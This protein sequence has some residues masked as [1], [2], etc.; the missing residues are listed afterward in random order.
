MTNLKSSARLVLAGALFT[1]LT[2]CSGGGYPAVLSNPGQSPQTGSSGSGGGATVNSGTGTTACKSGL[3]MSADSTFE[4]CVSLPANNATYAAPPPISV[5]ATSQTGISG[6]QAYVD[7]NLVSSSVSSKPTTTGSTGWWN[8]TISG[9]TPG[10][11]TIGI[12]VWDNNAPSY[13][14]NTYSA[15]ITVAASPLP[16]PPAGA[17]TYTNLESAAGSQGTWQICNGSCSG[18]SGPGS[19]TITQNATNAPSLSGSALEET[20]TGAAFNTLGYLKPPCPTAGCTSVSNFVDD[21]WF[22]I[23]A[24]TNQLQALEFDPDVYDGSYEY[25]MSMQC[26]SVSGEWRFWNMAAAQWTVN[27]SSGQ[28]I[29]TYPCTLLTATNQWHHFQLYAVANYSAHTYVYQTFVV[30]GVTVYQNLGNSYGA[31]PYTSSPSL[32]VEQQIDNNA[33]ATSNSVYYDNYTL[34]AW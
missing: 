28:T 13:S 26:D 15:T 16:T 2:A 34:T 12:N 24:S 27:S 8:G 30:D 7:G 10:T 9:V 29:P 25:F 31:R 22:Y 3:T 19:S 23:P 32:I 17:Q 33:S 5:Y 1:L 14:V 4:E 18:S 21:V 20:S 6:W 11:H